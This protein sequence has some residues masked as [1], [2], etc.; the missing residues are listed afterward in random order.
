[1]RCLACN[2]AMSD[3]EASRKYVNY[4]ELP[5]GEARYIGLCDHCIQDTDL[6]F[7]ENPLANTDKE[8]LDDLDEG[9]EE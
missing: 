2:C 9:A 1:M 7:V 3:R 6:V 8:E 5:E 4:Q